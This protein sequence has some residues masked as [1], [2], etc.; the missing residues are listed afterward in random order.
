MDKLIGCPGDPE[1][2]LVEKLRRQAR[3]LGSVISWVEARIASMPEGT[4]YEKRD[5]T[6]LKEAEKKRIRPAA[7]QRYLD[8]LGLIGRYR[9]T[10]SFHALERARRLIAEHRLSFMEMFRILSD[11]EDPKA[12]WLHIQQHGWI[13]RDIY[14][15]MHGLKWHMTE[16]RELARPEKKH[17]QTIIYRHYDRLRAISDRVLAI[18]STVRNPGVSTIEYI[19]SHIGLMEALAKL[20]ADIIKDHDDEVMSQI[21]LHIEEAFN[22]LRQMSSYE[23]TPTIPDVRYFPA[24]SDDLNKLAEYLSRE[25]ALMSDG[26][27][28]IFRSLDERIARINAIRAYREHKGKPPLKAASK[29]GA[30]EKLLRIYDYGKSSLVSAV[31]LLRPSWLM[32]EAW[33]MLLGRAFVSYS[34]MLF[35]TKRMAHVGLVDDEASAAAPAGNVRC[36]AAYRIAI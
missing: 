2:H 25:Q 27:W 4:G 7:L 10:R 1:R 19:S 16:G 34:L 12:T 24:Y 20:A 22:E 14:E 33:P 9:S 29:T 15:D 35:A 26:F 6:L 3:D 13:L 5:Y 28:A 17:M 21:N 36:G 30:W 32:G 11:Y 8:A 31:S 23:A 18:L